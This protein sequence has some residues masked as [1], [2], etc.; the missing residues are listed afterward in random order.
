MPGKRKGHL[1]GTIDHV[2]WYERQEID[3]NE[4]TILPWSFHPSFPD[5]E[6]V[7]SGMVSYLLFKPFALNRNEFQSV[8]G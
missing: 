2:K 5:K 4:K 6:M 3:G 7:T 1:R 8:L